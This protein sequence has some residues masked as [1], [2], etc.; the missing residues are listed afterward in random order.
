M[1]KLLSKFLLFSSMILMLSSCGMT[2]ASESKETDY[3]KVKE[4]TLDVLQTEEGKKS[5][6]KL[7]SGEEFKQ[8][9]IIHDHELQKLLS[10]SLTDQKTKKEWVK[11]LST[12][13]MMQKFSKLTEKQQAELLKMLMKDPEYQ[14]SLLDVLKDPEF[15]K[16]ILQ[17]L[18]SQ[19][20]RKETMKIMQELMKTPSFKEQSQKGKEQ[21]QGT[22]G[23]KEGKNK[24]EQA[25]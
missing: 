12:Q 21:G 20:Y 7:M 1:K 22:S 19:E 10:Q 15:S 25:S 13:E 14:K 8:Q 9:L 23:K 4:I 18:K 2:S 16:H 6:L 24:Q 17:L 5:L 11:I 3:Q